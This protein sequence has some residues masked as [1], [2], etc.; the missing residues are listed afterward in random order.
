MGKHLFA[1]G[2]YDRRPLLDK[3]LFFDFVVERTFSGMMRWRRLVR[4]D[5]MRL[6][7]STAMMHIALG[8]VLLQRRLIPE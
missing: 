2:A 7:V 8:S 5:E 3:T 1:N 6:D 4:D